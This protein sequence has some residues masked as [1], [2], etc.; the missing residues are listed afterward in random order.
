MVGQRQAD[1]QQPRT[2]AAAQ[3]TD[4]LMVAQVRET[5]ADQ[6][7]FP[8]FLGQRRKLRQRFAQRVFIAQLLQALI[9]IADAHARV[10]DR[11]A[12]SGVL[13]RLPQQ[14]QQ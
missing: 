2:L 13:I 11:R 3:R 7:H 1:E 4:L 10:E 12:F 5:G 9:V 6:R 14:A 8:L